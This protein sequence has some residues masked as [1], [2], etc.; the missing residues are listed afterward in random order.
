MAKLSVGR[1]ASKTYH[2]C[3]RPFMLV[4]VQCFKQLSALIMAVLPL[5]DVL[6]KSLLKPVPPFNR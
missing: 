3:N 5:K 1:T 2:P 6:H 4:S